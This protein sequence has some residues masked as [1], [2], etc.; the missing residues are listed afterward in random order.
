[1]SRIMRVYAR[2][3]PTNERHRRGAKTRLQL[4]TMDLDKDGKQ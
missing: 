4:F 2:C 3:T 1:M